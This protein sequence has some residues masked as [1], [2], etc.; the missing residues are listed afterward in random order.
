VDSP[1][2]GDP[3]STGVAAHIRG[4]H[5]GATRYDPAM[6]DEQRNAYGN[7]IYLCGDHHTQ[8]D[9]QEADFPV[10]RLV[11]M[12]AEHES[13]VREAMQAAFADIAFPELAQATAWAKRIPV[14]AFPREYTVVA[15]EAKIRKNEMSTPSRLTITM[16]LAIAPVVHQFVEH[17]AMLDPA[18]P[19]RL[20]SGFL[21]AYY[22]SRRDGLRGDD[23]F[24]AMCGF[25]QRGLSDQASRSAAVAVLVYLFERCEVFER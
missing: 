10:D 23:L 11:T 9:K 22:G 12:K 18:Y 20:K 21:A 24:D 7:L 15:P 16:G 2:A 4:E 17:E 19:D 1:S 3:V 14:E 25:A 13:K 5:A 8:I 6:T